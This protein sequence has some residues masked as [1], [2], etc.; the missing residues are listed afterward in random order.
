MRSMAAICLV[1]GLLFA[2]ALPSESAI[3][4]LDYSFDAAN[5]D[6]FGTHADAKA[7]VEAAAQDLNNAI[8]GTLGAIST[9]VY[10]G[11]NGGTTATFDWSLNFNNPS[12][13]TTVTQNPFNAPVNL[14]TVYVG[15]RPLT[16]VTLGVGGPAGAGFSLSGTGSASQWIGAVTAAQ[17]ASNAAMPR[18]SGPVMGTFSGS[19]TLGGTAANYNVSYGAIAGSL[20][21]DNDS[22]NNG[23]ADS[24]ALLATYWHYNHTTAV[25]AGKN[26]FYSVALHEMIHAIGIGTSDTWNS[27]IPTGTTDWTGSNV[28]TLRGNGTNIVT[29][30]AAHIAD[31]AM[32]ISISTGLAQEAVMDPSITQGTRK[33]LTQ[34]DLAF[35]RDIGFS[36]VPEPSALLLVLAAALPLMLARRRKMDAAF[37]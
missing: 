9:N 4:Q 32:S 33:G 36:T 17:N 31:G 15:M 27:L 20:S 14:V 30:D 26:D 37:A 22:D 21:L 7:A 24:D 35:L 8:V 34:L 25:A 11:V 1:F 19:S 2:W 23:T 5:G 10:A 13:G 6:F 12:T 16:G 29:G 28:I 18:G 3:V